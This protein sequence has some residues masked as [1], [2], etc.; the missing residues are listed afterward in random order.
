VAQAE[1]CKTLYAGSIPAA[2]STLAR[3]SNDPEVSVG[4]FDRKKKDLTETGLAGM[5]VIRSEERAGIYNDTENLSVTDFGMGTYKFRFELEV[6]LDD[7]R[8]PYTVNGKFKVPAK[9]GGETG[10]G[11]T[12]PIYAD[13]D[14]PARIEINWDRFI[15]EG[16]VAEFQQAHRKQQQNPAQEIAEREEAVR[17]A[18]GPAP[19]MNST[20][21][22]DL[23][24]QLRTGVITKDLYEAIVANNPDMR[25]EGAEAIMAAAGDPNAATRELLDL[26]LREGQ[27]TQK[28]YDRQMKYLG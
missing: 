1:V 21:K 28:Q 5:A 16:G 10:P 27:I 18:A 8:P 14:D 9:V 6:T 7:G 19:S 2:A 24:Y 3:A 20:R 4:L 25:I 26:Q 22:E 17:A 12:F 15:A 13:P 23:E 11:V